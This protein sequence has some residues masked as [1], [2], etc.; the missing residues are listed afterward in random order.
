MRG[1]SQTGSATVEQAGLAILLCA[2]LAAAIA[3]VAAGSGP[4][5]GASSAFSLARKLRCAAVGPGPVLAGPADRGLRAIARR[6]GA[7]ARPGA[8]RGAGALGDRLAARR[9]PP[10]PLVKLRGAR[11]APRPDRVEPARDRVRHGR[12]PAPIGGLA[13]IT[14]WLYRPTLGWERIVQPPRVGR[15]RRGSPATPLLD[16]AVPALVAA[17]DPGGPQPVRVRGRR[18]AAVAVAGRVG[19]SLTALAAAGHQ[20][21]SWCSITP[22]P[23]ASSIPPGQRAGEASRTAGGRSSW[24]NGRVLVLLALAPRR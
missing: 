23:A 11:P 12:R 2:L 5:A 6:R 22:M 19:R 20:R 9:L 8:G 10:L 7:G 13:E 1:S 15:D 16:D 24:T 4:R 3:A 17:R 21:A 14:Y 18:G